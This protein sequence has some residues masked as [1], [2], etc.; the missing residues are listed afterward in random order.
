MTTKYN[1]QTVDVHEGC[2]RLKLKATTVA[3]IDDI[4]VMVGGYLTVGSAAASLK[5]VGTFA[6][7]VDTTGYADGAEYNDELGAMVNA[8]MDRRLYWFLNGATGDAFTQADMGK[9][10]YIDSARAVT[11][12]S[13]TRSL[14]GTA[15][16]LSTDSLYVQV[17]P[18]PIGVNGL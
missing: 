1:G 16:R 13:T 5:F 12:T 9:K 10:A 6:E 15:V 18:E 17:S 8:P 4:A 14:C 2:L 7:A 3:A 11:K